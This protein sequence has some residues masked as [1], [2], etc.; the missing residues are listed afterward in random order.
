MIHCGRSVGEGITWGRVLLGNK[1]STSAGTVV[2]KKNGYFAT[3][4]RQLLKGT[5]ERWGFI[6]NINSP[7]FRWRSAE[8]IIIFESF[9]FFDN[10]KADIRSLLL[11][12]FENKTRKN[13][14][15]KCSYICLDNGLPLN[16]F[17]YRSVYCSVF[18][19]W[20]YIQ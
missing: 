14:Y 10:F 8:C 13:Q 20:K 7:L 3:I 9:H 1:K 4:G 5:S 16:L 6:E 19:N 2:R 11:M 12:I 15:S 17:I 18:F